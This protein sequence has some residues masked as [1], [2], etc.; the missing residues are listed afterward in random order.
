MRLAV[1]GAGAGV[2]K[3]HQPAL[4]VP[5]VE[6]VGLSDISEEPARSR[7]RELGV[8]YFDNHRVLLSALTP[9]AVVVMAPHPFHAP[10]ALD[11]L[12]MGAHVLVEKPVAVQ[13]AEADAMIATA[14]EVR[15]L[16]AVNLQQR[17]RA[18][19]RT[20][21]KLIQTGRL[22]DIQR[23]EIVA[24]WTRTQAYYAQAGW[25]GTWRGEG[26]GVLMNQAPHTLDVLCHLVG[27]PSRVIAWN[28]TLY[29]AIETEDTAQA[30]LEWPN[31]ALGTLLVST[32][33]AGE[34]ERFEIVGTRGGL[35]L[36]HGTLSTSELS[37]DLRDFLRDDPNP[38]AKPVFEPGTIE[39]ESGS[40]DH[41]AIYT[42]FVSAVRDGV[43]LI[44]DGTQGRL[45]LELANALT[46]SSRTGQVVDLPLDRAAYAELLEELQVAQ[47]RS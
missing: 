11:A 23:V 39:L 27:Q 34:P 47:V 22:G 14:V 15:R 8:P 35:L 20:A 29:H 46:Y 21:R 18:E 44:A 42:N 2:F 45:S 28:R 19:I 32:A 9:D 43:A 40:G 26:G 4:A 10:L 13:V 30:M 17:T 37:T 1:I 31:G 5:G 41:R 6:L 7:A 16:L 33:M 3:M 36:Q 12:R 38:Y 25:R 24:T